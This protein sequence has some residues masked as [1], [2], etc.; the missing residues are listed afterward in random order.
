MIQRDIRYNNEFYIAPV[1]NVAV[2]RGMRVYTRHA[3]EFWSVGTPEDLDYYLD[4]FV[5]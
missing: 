5:D 3:E 4:K 2:E 1:Y